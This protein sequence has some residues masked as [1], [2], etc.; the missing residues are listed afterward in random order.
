[1]VK[2]LPIKNELHKSFKTHC[3]NKGYSL[4][5]ALEVLVEAVVKTDE[6]LRELE[7]FVKDKGGDDAK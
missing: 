4:S 6:D 1:M 2:T 5:Y 3:I 7:E